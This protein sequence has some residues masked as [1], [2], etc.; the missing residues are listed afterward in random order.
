MK[1]NR[2][3]NTQKS[4]KYIQEMSETVHEDFDAEFM[5]LSY[6]IIQEHNQK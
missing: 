6:S 4:P 2:L 1:L 3:G 5:T